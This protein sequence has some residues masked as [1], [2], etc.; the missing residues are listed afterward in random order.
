MYADIPRDI[1]SVEPKRILGLTSRQLVMI[2]VSAAIGLP[3]FAVTYHAFHNVTI[4]IFLLMFSA[5]PV[6][7]FFLYKK[8]GIP[9]EQMIKDYL[10]WKYVHPQIRKYKTTKRNLDIANERKMRFASRKSKRKKKSAAKGAAGR[11][12]E[13]TVKT[14]KKDQTETHQNITKEQ[15]QNENETETNT[16]QNINGPEEAE[17]QTMLNSRMREG[18][19]GEVSV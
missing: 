14:G 10:K 2:L 12:E 17:V 7:A 3:V 19:K 13:K 15:D 4:S 11:N 8:D 1:K 5:G 9:A 6:F 18:Q 16:N